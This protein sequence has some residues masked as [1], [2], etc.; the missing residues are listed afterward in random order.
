MC[1][2]SSSLTAELNACL[3]FLF[4]TCRSCFPRPTAVQVEWTLEGTLLRSSVEWG[5]GQ[6]AHASPVLPA[7]T[8]HQ[9]HLWPQPAWPSGT[10][11]PS[12]TL[13]LP[14]TLY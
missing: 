1:V 6:A 10:S 7:W 3:G 11:S 14:K 12:S 9:I 5:V 2:P 13:C 4:S 8:R